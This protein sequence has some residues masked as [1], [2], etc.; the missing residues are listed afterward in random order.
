VIDK[1]NDHGLSEL[2]INKP[3]EAAVDTSAETA[4]KANVDGKEV[5]DETIEISK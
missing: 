4:T 2:T 1:N 3:T 5:V